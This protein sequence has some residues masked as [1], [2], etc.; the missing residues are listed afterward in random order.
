MTTQHPT[1]QDEARRYELW[2]ADMLAKANELA[3]RGLR[4]RAEKFYLLAA[5]YLAKA[6]EILEG[7]KYP[8]GQGEE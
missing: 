6:N 7:T 1:K 3:E 4:R 2:A 5:D 8:A